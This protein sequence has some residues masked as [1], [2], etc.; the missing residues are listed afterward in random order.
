MLPDLLFPFFPGHCGNSGMPA[1]PSLLPFPPAQASRQPHLAA[2]LGESLWG[3]GE[4]LL[5]PKQSSSLCL[6]LAQRKAILP[7]TMLWGSLWTQR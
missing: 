5:G 7:Q 4:A 6:Y 3:T 1:Y 2:V